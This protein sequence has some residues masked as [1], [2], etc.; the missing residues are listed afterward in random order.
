MSKE[1]KKEGKIKVLVEPLVGG[2]QINYRKGKWNKKNQS[3]NVGMYK[4]GAVY[5]MSSLLLNNLETTGSVGSFTPQRTFDKSADSSV[6]S[7]EWLLLVTS[8][9]RPGML[10]ST[11]RYT[12]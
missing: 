1:N 6:V 9:R 3:R 8:G 4:N 5:F 10:L 2:K 11:L 7:A 12:S